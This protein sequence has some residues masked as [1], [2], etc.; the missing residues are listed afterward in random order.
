M[1]GKY[2]SLITYTKNEKPIATPVWFGQKENKL[3]IATNEERYKIKRIQN[4]PSVQVAPCGTRGKVKGPYKDATARILPKNEID[5]AKELLREKYFMFRVFERLWKRK[6][7]KVRVKNS[8]L[9][10]L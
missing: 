5:V 10:F 2:I 4:N 1:E 9:K 8:I 7:K 6:E 3:Y